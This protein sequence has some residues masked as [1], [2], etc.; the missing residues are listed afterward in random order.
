MQYT[1]ELQF[2]E[3]NVHVKEMPRN[4]SSSAKAIYCIDTLLSIL[5]YCCL[6]S[7]IHSLEDN[8]GKYASKAYKVTGSV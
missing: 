3:E 4:P 2:Q 7:T 8:E 6:S 5:Y 1:G